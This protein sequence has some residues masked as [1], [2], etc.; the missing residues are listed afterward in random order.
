MLTSEQRRQTS[1][2]EA[3]LFLKKVSSIVP[4]IKDVL[5][6]SFSFR[7]AQNSCNSVNIFLL[8][9]GANHA[10]FQKAATL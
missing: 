8:V 6:D 9:Y 7:T 2:W 3:E 1:I 4:E 5:L 10:H